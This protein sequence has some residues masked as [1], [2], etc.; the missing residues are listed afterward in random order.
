ML[1]YIDCEVNSN[2]PE[3]S[4]KNWEIYCWITR[5]G[6]RHYLEHHSDSKLNINLE[7]G[8]PIRHFILENRAG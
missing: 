2:M 3:Y 6:I 1:Y 7:S 8:I 5:E 4:F